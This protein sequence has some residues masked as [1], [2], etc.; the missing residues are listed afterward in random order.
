MADLTPEAIA[1]LR[2]LPL[3]APRP[4]FY[5]D[6]QER[7]WDALPALLDAAERC[8]AYDA[9]LTAVMP[10]D[11]KDWHENDKSEWPETAAWCITNWRERCAAAE[12]R[13]EAAENLLASYF[14]RD[15]ER[16][17]KRE[18]QAKAAGELL[19]GLLAACEAKDSLLACYRLGKR[20]SEAL[21]KKLD[22]AK[23]TIEA[24]ERAG[25]K[26]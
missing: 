24:A 7:L 13:A 20:P 5:Y 16:R 26:P 9:K 2:K 11:F 15:D 3:H 18:A 1:E 8:A 22:K 21:F 4:L 10:P 23:E 6:P 25:V 17:A 19:R 14:Q 12:D